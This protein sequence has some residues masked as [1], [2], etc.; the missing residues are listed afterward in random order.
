MNDPGPSNVD[1]PHQDLSNRDP[2]NPGSSSEGATEPDTVSETVI[3]ALGGFRR[4]VD[5]LLQALPYIQRFRGATV[6]VKFGGHAMVDEALS[7]EFARDIVLMHQVGLKPVVVHGGGPPDRGLARPPGPDVHLCRGASGDRCRYPRGG[8]DGACGQGQPRAG[9]CDQ[10]PPPGG[11]WPVRLGRPAP[12][13]DPGGRRTRFRRAGHQRAARADQA[14]ARRGARSGDLDH[15]H[16][17]RA[18]LQHQRR[19][20]RRRGRRGARRR[21]ADL[22]HRRPPA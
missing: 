15:R 13:G 19:R 18:E 5:V 6:V 20:R 12:R 11:G 22:P 1:P 16:L 7:A 2:S 14:P 4:D 21:E 10:R 17:R 8:I 3:D 9:R